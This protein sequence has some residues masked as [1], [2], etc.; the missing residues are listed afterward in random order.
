MRR[1]KKRKQRERESVMGLAQCFQNGLTV[2]TSVV[3][4]RI[5]ELL[6]RPPI[7]LSGPLS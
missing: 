2:W 4:L 3:V 1:M 6:S 7:L 5:E